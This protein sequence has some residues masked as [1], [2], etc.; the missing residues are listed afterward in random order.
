MKAAFF[1]TVIVLFAVRAHAESSDVSVL[2]LDTFGKPLRSW[3]LKVFREERSGHKEV[4]FNK[5]EKLRL[6]YGVYRFHAKASLHF[7][8]DRVVEIATPSTVIVLAL[9]FR[10]TEH[11]AGSLFG[12]VRGRISNLE[13]GAAPVVLRLSSPLTSFLAEAFVEPDGSFFVKDV[14]PG[15][16]IATCLDR[17]GVIGY[18]RL[19]NRLN[20]RH[21][22]L[23]VGEMQ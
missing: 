16:Y 5:A 20:V 14:P 15:E 7:A 23:S 2:V 17:N 6:R 9:P 11:T 13:N 1:L 3:D 12:D 19:T 18:A 8:G 22:E 10:G 4:V 21:H